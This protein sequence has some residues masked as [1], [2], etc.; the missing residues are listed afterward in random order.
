[1]SGLASIDTNIS[2]VL[3]LGSNALL[4]CHVKYWL[5][6]MHARHACH[7]KASWLKVYVE[8]CVALFIPAAVDHFIRCIQIKA[9]CEITQLVISYFVNLEP[10]HSVFCFVLI[11][12]SA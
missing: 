7:T 1:L 3:R 4:N 12:V 8:G 5:A 10:L 6:D 2:P 9:T 11:Q